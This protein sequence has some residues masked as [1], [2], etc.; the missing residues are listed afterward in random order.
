MLIF[1]R[2]L[3]HPDRA[4]FFITHRETFGNEK[5]ES[6][7]APGGA[8]WPPQVPAPR[9]ALGGLA[10]AAARRR[11]RPA[12]PDNPRRGIVTPDVKS[13]EFDEM[14]IAASARR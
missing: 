11:E 7:V 6:T 4:R 14:T 9:R 13:F 12:R 8:D 2:A 5:I 3:R 1:R 10:V